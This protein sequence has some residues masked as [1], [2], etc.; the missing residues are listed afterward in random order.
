[1]CCVCGHYVDQTAAHSTVTKTHMAILLLNLSLHPL[2][3][4]WKLHTK[5]GYRCVSVLYINPV[6]TLNV[7]VHSTNT[8]AGA[9][10]QTF[11]LLHQQLYAS[12]E[13]P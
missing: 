5:T 6:A 8:H 4:L 9:A 7:F 13:L 10:I 12:C 2:P 3:L 11:N 1:M